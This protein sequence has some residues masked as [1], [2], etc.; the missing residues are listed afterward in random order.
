VSAAAAR[1]FGDK[2]IPPGWRSHCVETF[3][4]GYFFSC[5]G[6]DRG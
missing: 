6:G 4:T 5:N 1:V 2:M 3:K